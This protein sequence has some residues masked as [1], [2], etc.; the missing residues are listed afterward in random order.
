MI[1][2]DS[3][4]S[5]AKANVSQWLGHDNFEL[6][7]HPCFHLPDASEQPSLAM[8]LFSALD[9]TTSVP[10]NMYFSSQLALRRVVELRITSGCD[11]VAYR[12]VHESATASTSCWRAGHAAL[13]GT[14]R[15]CQPTPLGGRT[16]AG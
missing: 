9:V 7:S 13:K 12:P 2:A 4:M 11:E 6:V 5:G 3:Y 16:L 10:E 8:P 1:V 14:P 15:C